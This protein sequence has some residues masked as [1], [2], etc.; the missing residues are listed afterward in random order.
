MSEIYGEKCCLQTEPQSCRR[1]SIG[2]A[3]VENGRY[4]CASYF[5]ADTIPLSL[6]PSNAYVTLARCAELIQDGVCPRQLSGPEARTLL[7]PNTSRKN[8]ELF[9]C[10]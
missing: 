1:A 5:P 4:V 3:P 6:C 2:V 9:D 7:P 8:I 10:I